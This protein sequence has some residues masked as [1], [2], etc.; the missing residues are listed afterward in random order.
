MG[1]TILGMRGEWF[2]KSVMGRV[3]KRVGERF[4]KRMWKMVCKRV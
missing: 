1:L 3:W 4:L 2:C